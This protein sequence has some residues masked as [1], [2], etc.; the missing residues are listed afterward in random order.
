MN[1]QARAPKPSPQAHGWL[2]LGWPH[3]PAVHA[4]LHRLADGLDAADLDQVGLRSHAVSAAMVADASQRWRAIG[5]CSIPQNSV[6]RDFLRFFWNSLI[7]STLTTILAV[8][9][10]V[11]ATYAFSRFRFPG[12]RVPVL[13]GA[14]AQ[15]VPGGDLPCPA[16]H[17]D[18]L[19]GSREHPR[20]A[21]SHLPD[22]RSAAR[23][24]AAQGVLRQHSCAA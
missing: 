23:H 19:S 21:G 3:L 4:D 24:L 12:R 17:P 2:A 5:T 1:A 10:A 20:V 7:V 18:A 14:A 15:H 16:L 22:L 6:G 13:L 8:L 11:P 9:V